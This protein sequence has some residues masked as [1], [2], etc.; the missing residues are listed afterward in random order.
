[1]YVFLCSS[2]GEAVVSLE[3]DT[4]GSRTISLY[5]ARW[6]PSVSFF[7]V[8]DSDKYVGE[9]WGILV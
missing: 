9:R 8:D 5:S 3:P 4:T 7:D 1:M 6:F 2:I